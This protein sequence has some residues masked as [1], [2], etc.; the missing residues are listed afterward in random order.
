[1]DGA[2][3][4]EIFKTSLFATF[5]GIVLLIMFQV[6]VLFV[7]IIFTEI[8]NALASGG[9]NNFGSITDNLIK[10]MFP[11][12][13]RSKIP[14]IFLNKNKTILDQT[15]GFRT[16]ISAFVAGFGEHSKSVLSIGL[17]LLLVGWL[18]SIPLLLV[19]F[20]VVSKVFINFLLFVSF[21]FLPA[22]SINDNNKKIQ[23]W[24]E[25]Y[26]GNLLSCAVYYIGLLMMGVFVGRTS[27][28]LSNQTAFI[29]E[30]GSVVFQLLVIIGTGFSFKKLAEVSTA[31]IG[32]SMSNDFTHTAQKGY[33]AGKEIHKIRNAVKT[34]GA[35]VA[36]NAVAPK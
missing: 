6:L 12:N 29:G 31:F 33:K 28:F 36:A 4:N 8:T 13:V 3:A 30:I 15:W 25:K 7:N 19:I 11:D 16:F 10:N 21:P 24:K 22:F 20:D 27:T 9:D 18:I 2:K 17:S 1:M 32:G 26:I 34:K 23:I 5:K 35:S 14:S